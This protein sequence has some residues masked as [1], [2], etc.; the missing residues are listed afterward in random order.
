[1]SYEGL[2]RRSLCVS[3]LLGS[4][5][6]LPAE[7]QAGT[8]TA[9][10][11]QSG[12]LSEVVVTARK[13]AENAEKVPISMSVVSGESMVKLGVTNLETLAPSVPDFYFTR[14][15]AAADQYFIRGI[16]SGVNAGFDMAVG[17]V[18][19]GFFYGRSRYGR[20]AFLDASQ[21][22]VLKGPQG[23]LIGKNTSAGAIN[24]I[25]NEPTKTLQGYL[26]GGWEFTGDKG[27]SA[28]GAISAP[29]SSR[30]LGRVAFSYQNND[31]W[32]RNLTTGGM[33]PTRDDFSQ[34]TTLDFDA[35]DDFLV[36]L[37][38][39]YGRMRDTGNNRE[40]SKCSPGFLAIIQAKSW[41]SQED[42][43]FNDTKSGENIINGVDQGELHNTTF[44]TVDLTAKWTQPAFTVTSLTG[45]SG[46]DVFDGW[47]SLMPAQYSAYDWGEDFYQVT[48]ELRIASNQGRRFDYIGGVFLETEDQ[49]DN[50]Q[51]DFFP[52][53]VPPA[54]AGSRN[55]ISNQTSNSAAGFG[56]V[57]IHFTKRWTLTLGGRYTYEAKSLHHREFP[58][59]VGTDIPIAPRA[60]PAAKSHDVHLSRAEG[61]FSPN[62]SLQW[63]LSE[64]TMLYLN[65]SRGF[66]GGGYDLQFDGTQAAALA[67]MEF[68]GETV[69]AYEFGGK[70]RFDNDRARVNAD[71]FREDFRNLQVSALSSSA[72]AT[73]T[74]T[75]A[76]A[77]RSQGVEA[78]VSYRPVPGLTFSVSGAFLD[79]KFTS[80][81]G[82][83]CSDGQTA[84]E[85]CVNGGQDLSG[86]YL[87]FAPK[88]AGSFN[89]EYV[90]LLGDN[91]SID[92]S[93]QVV[94]KSMQY[95]ALTDDPNLIQS[96][97]GKI[98]AQVALSDDSSFWTIALIGRNLTDKLTSPFG[99]T[100]DVIGGVGSY[101]R[102]S[103][104]PREVEL[105]GRLHF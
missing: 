87:Q 81:P 86:H 29:L 39:Q 1:M 11:V 57:D 12:T 14:T 104:P 97:Y 5:S 82:A 60:G 95:L 9:Q 73:F 74:V 65:V 78:D 46:Y 100:N 32:V 92:M 68:S 47:G 4:I 6:A 69:T 56:E 93:A 98:N 24:I 52:T 99:N 54:L 66:K 75:N 67:Q 13:R 16:G 15:V 28:D 62:G 101:F 26:D 2:W 10:D 38:Y 30:L 48:Q 89:A 44:N 7:A 96:A 3:I 84:S 79:A 20:A 17:T 41:S 59:Q 31:G 61:N 40:I 50:Q 72:A 103:D 25:T 94:Y 37:A 53:L 77:A 91:Y 63:N 49:Q 33:E 23:A 22:E 105:E 21:V 35:T 64:N 51:I 83:Q 34:R 90:T 85:G 76:A 80:F 36:R 102:F 58:T 43:T 18:I 55:E 42:C 27:Y 71:V 8:N 70:F 45:Y 88:W 19:D